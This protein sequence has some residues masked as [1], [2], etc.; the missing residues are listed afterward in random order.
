MISHLPV[1][2]RHSQSNSIECVTKVLSFRTS[3]S[4]TLFGHLLRDFRTGLERL[5]DTMERLSDKNLS[6]GFDIFLI[7]DINELETFGVK[8]YL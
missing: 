1:F 6:L 2:M 8:K 3:K 4:R 7:A 5:S